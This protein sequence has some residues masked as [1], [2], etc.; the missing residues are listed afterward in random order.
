MGCCDSTS[1]VSSRCPVKATAHRLVELC[2]AGKFDQAEIELYADNAESVEPFAFAPGQAK[3]TSGKAAI[4]AKSE[5]WSRNT[6]VHGCV[7]E[8][9]FPQPDSRRFA[10]LF[11]LDATCKQTGQ[12]MKMDE[13]ALY[14]CDPAGK[15]LRAE[16]FYQSPEDC[17]KDKAKDAGGGCCQ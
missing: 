8:G 10:A 3:V 16:F 5:E 14:T 1:A 15:I 12:R 9:P 13:V 2:Q 11:R 17:C 7:I 6:I 4:R